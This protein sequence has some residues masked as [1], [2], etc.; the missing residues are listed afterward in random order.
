[1]QEITK[2]DLP[3]K[4]LAFFVKHEVSD[5]QS[6]TLTP[7]VLEIKDQFASK[8]RIVKF[9]LALEVGYKKKAAKGYV[10]TYLLLMLLAFRN[11]LSEFSNV[12][13]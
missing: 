13:R 3:F 6:L 10:I 5:E 11:S 9:E 12:R 4:T 8:L 1:M 2:V 7:S